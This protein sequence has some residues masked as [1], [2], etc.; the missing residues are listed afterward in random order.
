MTRERV[1]S[2]TKYLNEIR[3]VGLVP[4]LLQAEL[5]DQEAKHQQ[6]QQ[7]KELLVQQNQDQEQ[8]L[9]QQQQQQQQHQTKVRTSYG[10]DVQRGYYEDNKPAAATAQGGEEYPQDQAAAHSKAQ[11]TRT[12]PA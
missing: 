10:S 4:E 7:E 6:L 12:V 11:G 3:T 2:Q 9:Y 1:D 5:R 8:L